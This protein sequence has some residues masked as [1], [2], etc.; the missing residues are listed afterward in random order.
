MKNIAWWWW[1]RF[2][3]GVTAITIYQN[4]FHPHGFVTVWLVGIG[5]G[6]LTAAA[7]DGCREG[8]RREVKAKRER[9]RLEP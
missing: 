2:A 1:F 9:R 7:L 6:L 8:Y 5:V 4:T 3:A